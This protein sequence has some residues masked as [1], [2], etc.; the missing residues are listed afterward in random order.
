M[1]KG[2]TIEFEIELDR[3][4]QELKLYKSRKSGRDSGS[5]RSNKK[6][7]NSKSGNRDKSNPSLKSTL[8]STGL[9]NI[10]TSS[11]IKPYNSV[12]PKGCVPG[13]AQ[14]DHIYKEFLKKHN[15]KESSKTS[16]ASMM[17]ISKS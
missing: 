3:Y 15:A 12:Y 7:S 14:Y 4:K 2:R 6:R 11:K 17:Q 1:I 9:R 10:Y 13:D 8:G 5:T 16:S